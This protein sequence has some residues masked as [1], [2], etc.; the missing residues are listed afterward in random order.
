MTS[1]VD[2][3]SEQRFAHIAAE[4]LAAWNTHDV[5]KATSFYMEDGDYE[6][7][8]LGTVAHGHDQ[9]R[10]YFAEAF[11]AFPDVRVKLDGE[12]VARGGQVFAE[13]VMSGTHRG[14]FA[15]MPATGRRFEVRG[16]S[17]IAMTG[18]RIRRNRDYLDLLTIAKQL[19]AQS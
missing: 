6:D 4:Y 2:A 11:A 3:V 7:L 5:D 8:G 15:G 1:S 9:I 13:W 18:D 19:G 10:R 14:E 12:P 16:V 17:A